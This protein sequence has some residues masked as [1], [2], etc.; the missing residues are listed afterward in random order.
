MTLPGHG[1]YWFRLA[2][3][4]EAPT[5]HEEAPL[6]LELPV[7]V[8]FDTWRSFFPER[9]APERTAMAAK[10]RGQLEREILPG[11]LPAQR[12]FA[13]KAEPLQR[14]EISA[15]HAWPGEDGPWLW[16]WAKVHFAAG[17]AHTYSLP[18]AIGWG[19][20]DD[21][22]I[23]PLLPAALAKVRQQARVGI[24]YDAGFDEAFFRTV[25][26]A[27]GRSQELPFGPGVL[28]FRATAAFSRLVGKSPL[29]GMQRPIVEGTNTTVILGERLFLK[30]YRHIEK[31][32]S[33]EMEMGRFLTEVFRP[34]P[35]SRHWRDTLNTAKATTR[36]SPSLCSK[37]M[38][39]IRA[40]PG[41]IVSTTW[42]AFSRIA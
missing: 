40:M 3:D 9:V 1:F 21:E 23:R 6:P 36:W 31:G 35:I 14:V 37:V 29:Q 7:M 38:S 18:L 39:P 19:E 26:E 22:C 11:V 41:P 33:Q 15:L 20:A 27:M 17:E 30:L 32:G 42:N 2:T 28:G 24:L 25:V 16:L 10:L 4:T 8:L 34:I 13:A 5:W 12:W